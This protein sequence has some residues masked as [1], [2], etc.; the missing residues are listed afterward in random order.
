ME[1]EAIGL[2]EYRI[3][4]LEKVVKSIDESLKILANI[5]IKHADTR[6][7]LDRAFLELKDQEERLRIV[8]ADMPVIKM[9][10]GWVVS[11]VIGI[12]AI[13]GISI[14]ELVLKR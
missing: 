7:S 2:H 10:K 14:I 12:I 3:T 9:V 4:S 6:D 5:E 11:G 1:I 13:L 8:E